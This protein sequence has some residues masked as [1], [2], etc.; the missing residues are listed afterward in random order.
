M[1]PEPEEAVLDARPHALR[2]RAGF[3]ETWH[4]RGGSRDAVAMAEDDAGGEAECAPPYVQESE[5]EWLEEGEGEAE[6]E[7][8]DLNPGEEEGGDEEAPIVRKLRI[9]RMKRVSGPRLPQRQRS[10]LAPTR[11]LTSIQKHTKHVFDD[12]S[13][14]GAA[15]TAR[16]GRSFEPLK[17]VTQQRFI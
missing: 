11:L 1:E 5:E 16:S 12:E 4:A 14:A 8:E 13:R 9:K 10:R 7:G 3:L 15:P 17:A 2:M 6:D